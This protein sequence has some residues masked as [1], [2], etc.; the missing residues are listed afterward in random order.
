M[1]ASALLLSLLLVPAVSFAQSGEVVTDV[2]TEPTVIPS[3]TATIT[4]EQTAVSGAMGSWTVS[5]PDH[6]QR[7]G[8]G[9]TH[10]LADGPSGNYVVY[11]NLPSGAKATIRVYKNGVLD[12]LVERQQAPV[13]VYPGDAIRVSIHYHMN[14]TGSIAVQSDPDGTAFVLSGPNDVVREGVTPASFQDMPEGQYKV[15]YE[16]FAQ[17]CVKPAPKA[18]QLVK[19]ARL[20]FSVTFDCD[21]ATKVR[22]RTKKDA[23]K[24]LTIVADG[25]Q[26]QLQD[27]LQKDW[28]A[29]YVFEAAKRNI[30]AGYRDAEG[31]LTGLFG[32]GNDVTVA[33][34]AKIAHRLSGLSEEAFATVAPMNPAGAGSWFSPFLASAERRGWV[35]F[36][37]GTI[38]A[39]RPATRGEVVVTLLQAFDVPLKWQKGNV[40]TDVPV[41]YK[42]AAAIE[43]AAGDKIVG[44]RTDDDG[45]STGFFDPEAPITRAEIS[46]IIT[47]ILSTYTSPTSIRNAAGRRP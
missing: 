19:D 42:Y 30:L 17:G 9:A 28:F 35:I 18:G 12:K 1:R 34:L 16:S 44:G 7:S 22:E 8:S 31:K 2:P 45:E 14:K 3:G 40:F 13:A 33:E 20:S 5:L 4:I 32:P 46:K 23:Q 26:V 29:T 27:V 21:A 6:T 24:Y 11:A 47:T 37:D 39:G 41:S 38:E 15:Q 36:A 10:T 43:T 25:E